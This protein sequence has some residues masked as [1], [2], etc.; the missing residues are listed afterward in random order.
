MHKTLDEAE[1]FVK[2]LLPKLEKLHAKALLAVPYTVIAPLAALAKGSSLEI[3]AQ[4]MND[5]SEGAFTGEIAA[6]MLVSAGAS[7]VLLGHSERRRL[8]GESDADVRKKLERA[9]ESSLKPILC[10]GETKEERKEGKMKARLREQLFSALEGLAPIELMVAYEPVWAIGTGE[11]ATSSLAE[12]A[13]LLIRG[14]LHE[15]YGE[16]AESIPLLYGGSVTDE[17]CRSLAKESEINGLLVGGAS[18]SE[19]SFISILEGVYNL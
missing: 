9:F 8:F 14:Y 13:H 17:N 6:K 15:L 10:I 12:E 7:F 1:S 18:L 5:A 2:A 4:N 19:K 16:K 3:G 11:T